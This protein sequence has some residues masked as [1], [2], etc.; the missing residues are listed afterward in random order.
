[1]PLLVIAISDDAPIGLQKIEEYNQN[2]TFEFAMQISFLIAFL[3]GVLTFLSPCILPF[4]PAYFAYTFKEKKNI[5]KMTLFFFFGFTTMFMIMGAA[6]GWLGEQSFRV[7]QQGW[8]VR[9]AGLFIIIF[10]AFVLFG[11]GISKVKPKRFQNDGLGTFLFG[12]FFTLGWTACLGPILVGILGIGAILNNTLNSVYL[13]FFYSMGIFT[14]LFLMSILYD[15]YDF[16]K[17]SFIRGKNLKIFGKKIHSS[18][19]ISGALLMLLGGFILIYQGTS[20]INRYDF[21]KTKQFY[22]IFQSEILSWK[23]SNILGIIL[24][25]LLI[26]LVFKILKQEKKKV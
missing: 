18:N 6:A 19:L 21:F 23:Y 17:Y 4:L 16:S 26:L 12:V 14:P 7:I 20:K 11:K 3:A 9:M 13:M 25:G 8:L 2:A 10:G 15:K 5:T 24:L 1:M 22:Y